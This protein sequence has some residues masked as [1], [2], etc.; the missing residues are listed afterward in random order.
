MNEIHS[1]SDIYCSQRRPRIRGSPR[2]AL[3]GGDVTGDVEDFGAAVAAK[4]L[5]PVVAHSTP[6]L[7]GVVLLPSC[8]ALVGP[9]C[10]AWRAQ[11]S[12]CGSLTIGQQCGR[13]H[14]GCAAG[15]DRGVAR[16]VGPTAGLLVL[17]LSFD[18]LSHL[19]EDVL[20]RG[21]RSHRA[22][23]GERGSTSAL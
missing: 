2:G 21:A 10:S 6:V 4:Q 5:S 8:P 15:G 11:G 12:G 7:V 23:Q 19:L 13:G 1:H 3:Q 20:D 22:Q 16:P 17:G 9:L 14:S 18:M